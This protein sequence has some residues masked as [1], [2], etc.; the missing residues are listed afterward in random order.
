[1]KTE[2]TKE[3]LTDSEIL[4]KVLDTLR[5]SA[6]D[7]SKKLGYASP[8]TLYHVLNGINNL[9]DNLAMRL[10]NEFPQL[11]YVFLKTGKGKIFN[12]KDKHV[13]TQ[14]NLLGS[15]NPSFDNIP[16]T[17]EEIKDLLVI[18]AEELQNRKE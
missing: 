5:Y 10:V 15:P 13:Q 9:S 12:E 1:M 17:L 7:M 2:T 18:I 16:K 6:H 11:N 14:Q 8:G 3:Q 4:K